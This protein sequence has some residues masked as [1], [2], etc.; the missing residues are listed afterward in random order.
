MT[1]R[2]STAG[3]KSSGRLENDV[4]RLIRG[5]ETKKTYSGG[6]R[7]VR[8]GRAIVAERWHE[9]RTDEICKR[10]REHDRGREGH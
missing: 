10:V 9:I 3:R 2:R 6:G 7:E 8:K 4:K 5:N 1:N